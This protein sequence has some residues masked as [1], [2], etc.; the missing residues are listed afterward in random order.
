MSQINSFYGTSVEFDSSS[1]NVFDRFVERVIDHPNK[2]AVELEDQSITYS[3]LYSLVN[4]FA[5]RLSR[6]VKSGDIVCQCVQRSIEMVIGILSIFMCNATYCPISPYD[7]DQRRQ[8][9][10]NQTKSKLI[11]VHKATAHLFIDND[12]RTGAHKTTNRPPNV[13][14]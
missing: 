4:S 11:L 12:Q 3:E 13:F 1:R 10:I 9:L 7:S 5:C 8:T 2:I 6:F 14:L